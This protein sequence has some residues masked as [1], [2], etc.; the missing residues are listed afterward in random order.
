MKTNPVSLLILPALVA[1]CAPARAQLA[2]ASTTPYSIVERGPHHRVWQ[3]VTCE[4]TPVGRTVIH[5]NGYTELETGMHYWKD[6]QWLESV[7]EFEITADGAKA[8]RGQHQVYFPS[9]T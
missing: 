2:A 9:D 6:A 4:T 3:R 1:F 5:T 7:A 8:D